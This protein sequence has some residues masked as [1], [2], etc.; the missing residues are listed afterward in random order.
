MAEK[1]VEWEP[2]FLNYYYRPCSFLNT[3]IHNLALNGVCGVSSPLHAAAVI[4]ALY[5]GYL[6]VYLHRFGHVAMGVFIRWNGTVEW[7]GMEW[8]GGMERWNGIVE[9]NGGIVE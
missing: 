3:G 1:V 7:N 5:I 6:A 8:N 9:W 4:I 2:L